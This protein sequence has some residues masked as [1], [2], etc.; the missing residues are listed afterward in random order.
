[1]G[2]RFGGSAHRALGRG[3]ALFLALGSSA[4]LDARAIAAPAAASQETLYSD[5]TLIDGTGAAARPHQDLLVRG[6]RIAA[7][8][9]H[10]SLAAETSVRRVTP[11][12]NAGSVGRSLP[13]RFFATIRHGHCV[14]SVG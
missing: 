5:A 4:W 14:G 7:V 9:P 3:L 10:G 13:S 8:G 2:K 1:L 6:E 11:R 12:A